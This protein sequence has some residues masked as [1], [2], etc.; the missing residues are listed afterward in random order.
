M[1]QALVL[2]GGQGTRMRPFTSVLPKPLIPLEGTPILARVL[3]HLYASGVRH[4]YVSV[5]HLGRLIE[6]YFKDGHGIPLG[7][8][9]EF[10]YE[11]KPLGT[12]G[13]LSLLPACSE[14][15]LV[16]NGDLF[17]N[18]DIARMVATHQKTRA[19]LTISV[20]RQDQRLK[21]GALRFDAYGRVTDFEEKPVVSYWI[22]RGIYLVEPRARRWICRNE[23]LDI[24]ELIQRLLRE[25]ERVMV[26]PGSENEY[27]FDIGDENS[28]QLASR[29]LQELSRRPVQDLATPV[30][31]SSLP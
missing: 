12:V 29:Y 20:E 5:N 24:P 9:V 25:G 27:W 8:Q 15:T 3:D 7:M 16:M 19:T 23:E 22:N 1:I 26:C 18:T 21:Y 28:H 13:A 14:P 2:A 30:G 6:C 10:L 17:T 4:A 31:F 11:S